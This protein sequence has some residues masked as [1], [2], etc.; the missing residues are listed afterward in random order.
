MGE[1]AVTQRGPR[2]AEAAGLIFNN[3]NNQILDFHFADKYL[4]AGRD[5]QDICLFSFIFVC[6]RSIRWQ[7]F[8]VY[9]RVDEM[10][11]ASARNIRLGSVS[12]S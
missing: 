8:G 3:V 6:F 12:A 11:R 9:S 10:L 7:T 2:E 1:P 4:S 5:H